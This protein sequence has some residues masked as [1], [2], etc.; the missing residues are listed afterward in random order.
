MHEYQTRSNW[1]PNLC[2]NHYFFNYSYLW[3]KCLWGRPDSWAACWATGQTQWTLFI[4]LTAELPQAHFIIAA[5]AAAAAN[6]PTAG[7]VKRKS[8]GLRR[9]RERSTS[10][11]ETRLKKH[12]QQLLSVSRVSNMSTNSL[13]SWSNSFRNHILCLIF[14]FRNVK[15]VSHMQ[16]AD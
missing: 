15:N 5:A 2:N 10:L 4:T 8:R 1:L 6:A 13:S 3:P 9:E 14:S 7:N 16:K 12:G 11:R